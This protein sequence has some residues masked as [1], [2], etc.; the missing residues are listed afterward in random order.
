MKKNILGVILVLFAFESF[1][2]KGNELKL[3]FGFN[4]MWLLNK[5]T[6]VALNPIDNMTP[7]DL[8]IGSIRVETGM[9]YGIQRAFSISKNKQW[10]IISGFQ[11]QKF[12][13]EVNGALE[14]SSSRFTYKF[15]NQVSQLDVPILISYIKS[16]DKFS[17]G[18]DGGVFKTVQVSGNHTSTVDQIPILNPE[19]VGE[20]SKEFNGFVRPLDKISL[21]LAPFAR[22]AITDWL[23]YEIQ[24][25]FRFQDGL[26]ALSI[27]SPKNH[28]RFVQWGINTGLVF[29]F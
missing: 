23:A 26:R 25:F 13:Y 9:N 19:I 29:N 18:L 21:H 20:M 14:T 27:H 22:V 8:K 17:F 11:Y 3:N 24:P 2:Q 15:Y 4:Q 1:G 28:P 7:V 10:R 5:R 6:G 12:A 16:R